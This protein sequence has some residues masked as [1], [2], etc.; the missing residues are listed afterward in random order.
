[1]ILKSNNSVHGSLGMVI[2][3][4]PMWY[5]ANGRK[6]AYSQHQKHKQ[7]RQ[8]AI[9][10]RCLKLEKKKSERRKIIF[11]IKSSYSLVTVH[12]ERPFQD[13]PVLVEVWWYSYGKIG[14]SYLLVLLEAHEICSNN[15]LDISIFWEVSGNWS[16]KNIS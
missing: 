16:F 15:W 4:L 8:A 3:N 7:R 5:D 1:M 13:K 6:Q 11:T 14:D 10:R 9:I 12:T 2:L